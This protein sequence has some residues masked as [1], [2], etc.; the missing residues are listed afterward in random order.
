VNNQ[1]EINKKAWSFRAY[2]F[3]IDKYGQPEEAAISMREKPQ[4]HLR[5]YI[6]F[7]VMSEIKKLPTYSDQ[8]VD[9]Q[10]LLQYLVRM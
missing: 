4:K 6:I 9:W 7:S 8:M 2:D 3:W 5:R 1:S 10:F